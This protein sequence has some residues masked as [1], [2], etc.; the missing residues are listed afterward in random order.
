M[1]SSSTASIQTT[2]NTHEVGAG[3]PIRIVMNTI[4]CGWTR[5]INLAAGMGTPGNAL[6]VVNE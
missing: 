1:T 4:G 3:A 2:E 6:Q 5:I